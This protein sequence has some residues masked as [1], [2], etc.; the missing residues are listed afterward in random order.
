MA[1]L[2]TLSRIKPLIKGVLDVDCT[3]PLSSHVSRIRDSNMALF[4]IASSRFLTHGHAPG[5][6]T[7]RNC[8]FLLESLP[9][10]KNM[11]T[12]I[13]SFIYV[14]NVS[15]PILADHFM[16]CLVSG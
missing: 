3:V 4:T 12:N 2:W 14:H 5:T 8:R 1:C 6:S 7:F 16:F 13:H 15:F 9:F 11:L 10:Y